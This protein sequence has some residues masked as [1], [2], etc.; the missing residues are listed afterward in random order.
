M[1][2][3]HNWPLPGCY[4]FGLEPS[5][6]SANYVTFGYRAVVGET[7]PAFGS[8]FRATSVA[9]LLLVTRPFVGAWGYRRVGC[10]RPSA[11]MG[12]VGCILFKLHLIFPHAARRSMWAVKWPG[13]AYKKSLFWPT[14]V[15][16]LAWYRPHKRRVNTITYFESLYNN[17]IFVVEAGCLFLWGNC[18]KILAQFALHDHYLFENP[19][20]RAKI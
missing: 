19:W 9:W 4:C 3:R 1:I 11:Y 7:C 18:A 12:R 16:W 10:V 2:L 17:W 13:R 5:G 14:K 8:C 6:K 15:N 20:C